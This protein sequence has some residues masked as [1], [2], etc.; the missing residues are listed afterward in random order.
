MCFNI[1]LSLPVYNF[2]TKQADHILMILEG[3]GNAH[4]LNMSFGPVSVL[5]AVAETHLILRSVQ[6]VSEGHE[7]RPPVLSHNMKED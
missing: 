6:H 3:M 4:L 7:E 1:A 5:V 2:L